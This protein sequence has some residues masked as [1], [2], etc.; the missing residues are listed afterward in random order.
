MENI[1]IHE[2]LQREFKSRN[3]SV[4]EVARRCAIPKRTLQDWYSAKTTPSAKTLTYTQALAEFLNISLNHLLFNVIDKESGAEV[5]MS[6]TFKDGK[7]HYRLIIE[8]LEE[9]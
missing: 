6:A 7:S 9:S 2:V 1:K 5:I 4:G 3:L 8:K